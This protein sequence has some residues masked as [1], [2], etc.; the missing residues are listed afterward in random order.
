MIKSKGTL[1]GAAVAAVAAIAILAGVGVHATAGAGT[2]LGGGD[3]V[4]PTLPAA[5]PTTAPAQPPASP[6]EPVG[7]TQPDTNPNGNFAG[8]NG[9]PGGLPDT[10]T[11]PDSAGNATAELLVVLSLAGLALVCT[12]TAV[13]ARRS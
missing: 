2:D 6:V 9:G 13:N 3:V 7:A 8:V 4:A 12:G 1:V 11:G 10:G 5:T